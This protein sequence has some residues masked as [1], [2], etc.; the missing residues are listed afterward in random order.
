M[1]YVGITVALTGPPM[2]LG[3]LTGYG[4]IDSGDGFGRPIWYAR[5]G[6]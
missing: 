1:L 2:K 3:V 5:H 4:I 6:D